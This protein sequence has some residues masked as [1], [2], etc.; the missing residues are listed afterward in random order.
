MATR[1]CLHYGKTINYSCG[2]PPQFC[3]SEE[4]QRAKHEAKRI[5]HNENHKRYREAH[6]EE[7]RKRCKEARK[8]PTLSPYCY[9]GV[10]NVYEKIRKKAE[11]RERENLKLY[12][13]SF[14][15]IKPKNF[16]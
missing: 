6:A 15:N 12:G 10:E 8:T 14:K 16:L 4:C 7:W 11:E 5:R 2:F 1:T 13:S 9:G 3:I